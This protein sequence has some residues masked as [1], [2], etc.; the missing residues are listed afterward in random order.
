MAVVIKKAKHRFP[1]GRHRDWSWCQCWVKA[2]L[3]VVSVSVRA[4]VPDS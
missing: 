2:D 1:P 3:S 4:G